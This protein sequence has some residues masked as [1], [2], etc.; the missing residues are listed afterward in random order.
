MQKSKL[1][2]YT[3]KRTKL[4]EIL[5]NA[6]LIDQATLEKATELQKTNGLKF[7]RT[8]ISMGV[9]EETKL[10]EFL[11]SQLDVP[12]IDL[13]DFTVDPA[14]TILLPEEYARRYQAII[15]RRESDTYLVGMADPLDINAFDCVSKIL[16]RRIM[17]AV[18]SEPLLLNLIDRIYLHNQEISLFAQKLSGE[19]VKNTSSIEDTLFEETPET[20]EQVTVI[21]LLNALF[22]EAFQMRASDIHLEPDVSNL[23]VRF[24]INGI[25]KE[26]ILNDKR[27]LEVLIRRLK[28]RANLD[29]SEQRLPQD[30]RFK[31]AIKGHS[32]DVRLSTTPTAN[33]ESLVM[34]LL[35]QAMPLNEL[36]ELGIPADMRTR[37][38][39]IYNRPYGMLLITGPTGSGKTTTLYS[40]LSKLNVP[41]RN[42]ITVEDP[43]EYS[44][45]RVNQIQ[46]NP[47]IKLTFAR[48]LRAIVRQDPDVIM[49][50][51]IRDRIS[52]RI[53]MRAAITGHF[54]LATLHTNNAVTA[55]MRLVDM[56]V[57]GYM[58]A[59]AVKAVIGQR[60]VRLLCQ[61]C[62]I[63]SKPDEAKK[64]WLKTMGVDT[65]LTFKASTGCGH[66]SNTGYVSRVGVYE[67]LELN[68]TMMNALKLNDT[69]AFTKAALACES[70]HSLADEV[71]ILLKAGKT[72]INEAMRV[73][74]QIDD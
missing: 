50:G 66:C 11:S 47:K 5:L 32:F 64:Q 6:N 44:I 29:I 12:Y 73:I 8:L 46:V 21:N 52:A 63:D 22:K 3:M 55:A 2:Q 10:L 34:R 33:G 20:E 58:V 45:P 56:G 61:A 15:L 54:V 57:E 42:I 24:R 68:S 14:L 71:I 65:E 39:T 69:A 41:E 16:E 62:L 49:V 27:I 13:H 38:E 70:Y 18:V 23:R 48:I 43:V 1:G 19:L 40:I 51:E 59:S 67:L 74:G 30:G 53:A 9:L 4:G 31:F 60:L 28:L 35:D 37:M 17:M 7:G 72:S 25:L 26:Y 36:A